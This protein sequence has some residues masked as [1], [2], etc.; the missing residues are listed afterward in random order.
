[1]NLGEAVRMWDPEPGW[2]NTASYGIPPEP[3]VEALQGAL[4]E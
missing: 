3:A 4:G 2:L 1:M